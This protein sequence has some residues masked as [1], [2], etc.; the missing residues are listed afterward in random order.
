MPVRVE[1]GTDGVAELVVDC[2]PARKLGR[3]SRTCL[4][5]VRQMCLEHAD[6]SDLPR[7]LGVTWRTL[8]RAM[9]PLSMRWPSDPARFDGG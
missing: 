6:E 5:G 4:P 1:V 9:R 2:P 7:Q 8:W 3:D